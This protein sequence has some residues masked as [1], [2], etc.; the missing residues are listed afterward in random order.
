MRETQ[1][2][3]ETLQITGEVQH[4]IRETI[5]VNTHKKDG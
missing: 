3:Y 5:A 2:A 1:G 4:E